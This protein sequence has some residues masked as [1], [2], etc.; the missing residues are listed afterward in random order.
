MFTPRVEYALV[1][2]KIRLLPTALVLVI[3]ALIALIVVLSVKRGIEVS[4]PPPVILSDTDRD[5]A[6]R[7]IRARINTLSVT[8]PKLGGRFDVESIDW[9]DRGRAHVTYG[10]G[11]STL[12]GIATVL[13]GS[14]RVRVES[15]DVKE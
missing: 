5:D 15:F 3:V 10:D 11:E 14:G 1:S 9:D 2:M 6:D 13:T 4:A 12:E 7:I 8:P